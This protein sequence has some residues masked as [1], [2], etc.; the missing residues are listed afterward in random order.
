MDF[1]R[2]IPLL[3]P[4]A[5]AEPSLDSV[6]TELLDTHYRRIYSLIYRIVNSESDAADLT[7]ETFVRVYRAL[8]RLR[9]EG[10]AY[11]WVRRIATNLCL[12]FIRRR[13]ASPNVSSIDAGG[14]D[15]APAA[16]D[17]ADS[18]GDPER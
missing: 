9:A 13:N 15:D 12:D 8:P 2:P 17:L 11:S 18:S 16:W 10:A 1:P 7:Q 3:R 5:L 4:A 6:F 14:S